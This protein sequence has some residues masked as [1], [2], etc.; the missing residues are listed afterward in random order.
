MKLSL[1]YIFWFIFLIIIASL[2]LAA[3]IILNRPSISLTESE[4]EQA[5]ENILGRQVILKDNSPVS[6][7]T[8][9]NGKYVSFIYP[10]A[11]KEFILLSN[12]QPA[13]FDDLEHFSFDIAD[14]HTHFFSQVLSYPAAQTL[15]DYPGVRLRQ[16]ES[17]TYQQT[18]VTSADKQE[19][20]AFAKYDITSG[21]EK[22]AF[23][24]VNGK[25]YTFSVQSPDG[26]SL[27]DLFNRLIPTIKF[28]D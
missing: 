20:L 28:L 12:G 14:S 4:K 11:G 23:F 17:E 26:Q 2:F 6:G 15:S 5:L 9:H 22:I 7:N 13:K 21:F 1:K 19:G 27:N 24:L 25:I 8:E 3:F 18:T 10:K 16:G